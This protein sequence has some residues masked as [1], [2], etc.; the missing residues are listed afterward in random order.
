MSD[1]M[2]WVCSPPCH[3]GC[4]L[5]VT[6]RLRRSKHDSLIRAGV[7]LLCRYDDGANVDTVRRLLDARLLSQEDIVE[8]ALD[9]FSAL[10]TRMAWLFATHPS[11]APILPMTQCQAEWNATAQAAGIPHW[12][13]NMLR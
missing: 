9:A 2:H 7:L 6:K 4:V 1:V 5:I 8:G 13:S 10:H 12:H 11:S 3:A